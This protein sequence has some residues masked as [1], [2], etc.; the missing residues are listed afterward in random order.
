MNSA[1]VSKMSKFLAV[2]QVVTTRCND[3]LRFLGSVGGSFSPSHAPSG[4]FRFR[5]SHT[6]CSSKSL[7]GLHNEHMNMRLTVLEMLSKFWYL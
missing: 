3:A 7:G 5:Y 1:P 2:S 4:T 6:S